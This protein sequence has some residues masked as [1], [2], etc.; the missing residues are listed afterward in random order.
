MGQ[1]SARQADSRSAAP[2]RTHGGTY[3]Q[4]P[5]YSCAISIH[6]LQHHGKGDVRTGEG[7]MKL[8]EHVSYKAVEESGKKE[9][10]GRQRGTLAASAGDG[11]RGEGMGHTATPARG[12]LAAQARRPCP[13]GCLLQ[14]AERSPQAAHPTAAR[15][16]R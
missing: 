3:S 15:L 14:R 8:N 12:C 2:A 11:E 5:P 13:C 7:G 6:N 16:A 10:W 9:I 4:Q 1:T